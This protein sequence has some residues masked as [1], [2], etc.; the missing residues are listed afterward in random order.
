MGEPRQLV[1]ALA[2]NPNVGKSTIFNAL[3][4]M[5]Q[6]TGNW[7]GKTVSGARGRYRYKGREHLLVDLPGTYSLSPSSAEEEVAR[8]FICFGKPDAVLCVADAT[9]L[10][11]NLHLTLQ[12]LEVTGNVVLCVNLLD[13]AEKKKI[14]IDLKRLSQLLGIPVIG[15]SARSGEGLEELKGAVMQTALAKR[16][17]PCSFS[18]PK[19]IERSVETLLPLLPTGIT[20]P[21]PR[22]LARKLLD[23][24]RG[25]AE[26]LKESCGVSLSDPLLQSLDAER[27]R[28]QGIGFDAITLRDSMVQVLVDKAEEIGRQVVGTEYD[29]HTGI[30]RKIDRI[31]TSRRFGIPLM[32]L[33]LGCILWL[34]I[35]G[36]NYPSAWLSTLFGYGQEALAALFA[37]L[38]LPAWVGSLIC[39]GVYRTVTW[40]VSVMLPPMLIFF[41]LFTLLEDFGYLPRIAFNLDKYFCK[42]AACGKQALTI[43]MG[44]GC[45]AVGVSGC[46]IIDSPRE[47]LI[48]ILTN[49][50]VPCNGRFPTVIAII[51]MFFTAS[52]PLVGSVTQALLLTLV[53]VAGVL[54]TLG[55]SKL[56]S[57]TILK[58]VP[59]AFTLELPP[60]R[61]PQI[62][63]VIVRSVLDRALFVLGRAVTA[64]APAGVLIWCMANLSVGTESLLTI[65]GNALE[66]FGA[67]LGVDG[68]IIL[69]FLLGFPANEI[70]IPVLLMAYLQ[71]GQLTDYSGL[72][73]L[74]E[75]LVANGWTMLTAVNVLIL[76]LFHFPCATTCLTIRKETGSLKWTAIAFLLPTVIGILLC[77]TTTGISHMFL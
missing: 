6:H 22:F 25:M 68:Y 44:L 5:H 37:K 41:P 62:G 53:I 32:L 65:C 26:K 16:K 34:T 51:T 20:G 39:G 61:K 64:A 56:L 2:G 66:P 8:D 67:L 58:G 11:R 15:T 70:V 60:Y 47:R 73:A 4:G 72:P 13:E 69:A 40:V 14:R 7:P 27:E 24:E 35:V 31:V 49:A 54:M 63:R 71:T 52:L 75:L 74:H 3:T 57:K 43:C 48:A 33:L 38:P 30:D 29:P 76:C 17:P 28:L 1:I 23:R 55:C 19:E 21:D 12:A 50:M 36:A 18:Y 77:L 46:R 42:A 59:S 45:N 10:S 9:C